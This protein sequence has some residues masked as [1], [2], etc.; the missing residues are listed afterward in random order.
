MKY[1]PNRHHRRSIRL[2][3]YD[4]SQVGAYFLTICIQDRRYLLGNISQDK[5]LLN[6]AGKMVE[7]EWHK[8]P[9]RFNQIQLDHSVIMPNHFHGII[10]IESAF[11]RRLLGEVVGAFK[12]ITSYYYLEGIKNKMWPPLKN[13]LWQRNYYEHIIRSEIS[14]QKIRYYVDNNPTT[15]EKDILFNE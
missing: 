9:G 12:S 8:L 6:D 2:K 13:K 3:E 10:L 4:Y 7:E 15:W 14:L 5:M 1:N 11:P